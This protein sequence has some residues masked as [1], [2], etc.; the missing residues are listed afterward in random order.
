MTS[1][2]DLRDAKSL[3]EPDVL[4]VGEG[5]RISSNGKVDRDWHERLLSVWWGSGLRS[6]VVAA[7]EPLDEQHIAALNDRENAPPLGEPRFAITLQC[8]EAAAVE[9]AERLEESLNASEGEDRV[10]VIAR[11]VLDRIS[12]SSWS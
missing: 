4:I 6:R 1:F 2:E 8:S 12:S 11:C 3:R 7:L 9:L 5:T 10:Q